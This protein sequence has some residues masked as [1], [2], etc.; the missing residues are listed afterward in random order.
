MSD[1]GKAIIALVLPMARKMER[2]PIPARITLLMS[3][4]AQEI[5]NLPFAERD[6]ALAEVIRDLPGALDATEKGMREALAYNARRG[7]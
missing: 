7:L 2:L 6:E 1:A 5:C 3:L 4:L